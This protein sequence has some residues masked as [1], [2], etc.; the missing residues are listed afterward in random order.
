MSTRFVMTPVSFGATHAAAGLRDIA[1]RV[2]HIHAVHVSRRELAGL[3]PRLLKDI[4]IS[5]RQAYDESAR[6]PWDIE[7]AA[8]RRHG[9]DG[10]LGGGGGKLAALRM[11]LRMAMRRW[12]TRQRISG[13]DA[14]TLRDIGVTY[15]E[16]EREANKGFWQR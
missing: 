13:L 16:A 4:G 8:P 7:P 11:S 3:E 6:A 5:A 1:R 14:R 9:R 12:R 2:A 10:G 15:A